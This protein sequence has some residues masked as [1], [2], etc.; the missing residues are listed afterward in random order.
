MSTAAVTEP[1]KCPLP[2]VAVTLKPYIKSRDEVFR[3][4]HTL[5]RHLEAEAAGYTTPL[6]NV[7]LAHANVSK[8]EA[9]SASLSGV[10]KA[11]L[12]AL[13]SHIDA[14]ER[15]DALRTE[16]EQ[17]KYPSS[18][19]NFFNGGE[20]ADRSS[21]DYLA[22][23]RQKERHRKLKVIEMA[24]SSIVT[25]HH[26]S[27]TGSLEDV[28]KEKVGELPTPPSTQPTQSRD[29][30]VDVKTMALKKAVISTKQRVDFHK[31]QAVNGSTS[32]FH[33]GSPEAEIAGLR[34]ALQ[35]LSVWMEDHLTI[36]ADG[37]LEIEAGSDNPANADSAGA[38]PITLEDVEAR[39]EQYLEARQQM[40]QSINMSD[41]GSNSDDNEW[42]AELTAP[43]QVPV[44]PL[45]SKAN[46]AAIVPF[47]KRL[48][49]AKGREQS[50]VQQ[51]TY[52]RKQTSNAE[53]TTAR[54][55]Q[56][57]AEESH[58]VPPGASRGKDWSRAATEAGS[59]T[60][61]IATERLQAGEDFAT[62]AQQSHD[63]IARLPK[64]LERFPQAS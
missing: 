22:L 19:P 61:K 45:S 15:Y 20:A 47:I 17:L 41:D 4:R 53:D 43:R 24:L 30:D 32:N 21:A 16:L 25:N 23:L 6:S 37:E 55:I 5:Q 18:A 7:N 64:T 29:P 56:R 27:A 39:Y 1:S 42:L 28:I 52:V 62:A 57:L 2:E 49:E 58:L 14:Q 9:R 50:Q 33:V 54:L 40:V 8:L 26:A 38:T 51:T 36:I 31:K 44:P 46:A 60:K 48:V 59:A 10:R 12:R 11:Y 13:A 34:S 63:A 35:E 3:V